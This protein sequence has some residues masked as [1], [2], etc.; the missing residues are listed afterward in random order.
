MRRIAAILAVATLATTAAVSAGLPALAAHHGSAAAKFFYV[1]LGDSLAQGVQPNSA[2]TNVETTAGYPDQLFTAL[3]PGN[4]LLHLVKLGCPGETTATMINGGLCTYKQPSQ[5]AQAVAFLKHHQ[6]IQLITI[7]IGANDLNPC[8]ALP[9]LPDIV[10][11][12]NKVIPVA[13]K[14]LATIMATLRGATSTP[15]QIIGMNYYVPQLAFWLKGTPAAKQLAQASITLG[16]AFGNAL[17][18]VYTKFG[19]QVADVFK[20]FHTAAF[21]TMVTL[22]AFGSVPKDVAE[23]CSLTWQCVAPPRGPNEH[24]NRVGY[25]I[26]ANAFLQVLLT[27][28]TAR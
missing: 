17:A 2:G 14:N 28:P 18:G 21:K 8:V 23:L 16:Q 5:L 13:L 7:D 26:I 25:A 12:L 6:H 1:S 22:P 11:C 3:R 4:P 24:A 15:I 27:P 19:A 10:K 20:A 9:T